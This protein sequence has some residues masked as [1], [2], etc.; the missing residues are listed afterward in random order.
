MSKEDQKSYI[1]T[2]IKKFAQGAELD[3]EIWFSDWA[4]VWWIVIQNLPNPPMHAYISHD[5][6][7]NKLFL[8][9]DELFQLVKNAK[10]PQE[11]RKF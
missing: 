2:K 1:E 4:D 10:L 7:V 5:K 9:E 3:M 6:M 8:V 11:R